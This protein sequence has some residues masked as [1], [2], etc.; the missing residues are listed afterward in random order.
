MTQIKIVKAWLKKRRYTNVAKWF[1]CEKWCLW[2]SSTMHDDDDDYIPRDVPKGHLA[3]YV[4]ENQKRFVINVKLL[5]YPLFNE[6]LDQAG[7]EYNFT[8]SCR[9]YI[10]CDEDVFRSVVRCAAAPQGRRFTFCL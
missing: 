4:G 3:V 10:P 7:E 8:T 6:M 1:T 2:T 5:K 9:L